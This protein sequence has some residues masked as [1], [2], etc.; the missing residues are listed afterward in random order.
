MLTLVINVIVLYTFAIF[1]NNS[2]RN[3]ILQTYFI[4][5]GVNDIVLS[6]L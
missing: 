6:V 3:N 4:I 1:M 5:V 2:D